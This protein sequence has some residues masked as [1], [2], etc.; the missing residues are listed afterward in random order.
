MRA[1]LFLLVSSL[2][3]AGTETESRMT[4]AEEFHPANIGLDFQ[5]APIQYTNYSYAPGSPTSRPGNAILASLEWLP[6]DHYGKLGVGIG[7]GLFVQ[8]NQL[9]ND[10]RTASL[11][12]IP[13]D[14]HV[15]YYFDYIENQ[16]LVPFA[17]LGTSLTLLQQSSPNGASISPTQSYQ[18]WEYSFGGEICLNAIDGHSSR[19][20]RRLTGIKRSYVSAS[21]IR[22]QPISPAGP[23]LSYSGYRVGF[24]LEI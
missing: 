4:E 5:W 15:S 3:L 21:Y 14:A 8:A 12:G 20:L 2:A 16:L 7:A 17:S 24:R 19:S 18:G 22:S 23:D 13:L 9:L 11:T 10:G 6:L 1:F